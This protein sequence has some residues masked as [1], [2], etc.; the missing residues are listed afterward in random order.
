M[1]EKAEWTYIRDL[2]DAAMAE[3]PIRDEQHAREFLNTFNM[4]DQCALITAA[5]I[6][7]DHYG[8]NRLRDDSED[9][10]AYFPPT[11]PFS[12]FHT[13]GEPTDWIIQPDKH[14]ECFSLLSDCL[15]EYYG[16]FWRCAENSGYDLENF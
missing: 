2:I 13:T 8:Q 9:P 3:L 11:D 1:T 12:R 6:G 7:K 16:T 14:A 15:P 4:S 5:R 10:A